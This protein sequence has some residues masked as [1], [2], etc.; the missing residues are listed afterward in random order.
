MIYDRFNS[1]YE[2]FSSR[3]D[4]LDISYEHFNIGF[5][6]ANKKTSKKAVDKVFLILST[7]IIK[8]YLF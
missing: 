3:Y 1:S 7:A 8:R 4:L 2:R 5:D 6:H